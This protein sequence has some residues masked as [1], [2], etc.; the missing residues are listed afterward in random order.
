VRK[1]ASLSGAMPSHDKAKTLASL[2]GYL[3]A[4]RESSGLLP[5]VGDFWPDSECIPRRVIR[6]FF[7]PAP[8]FTAVLCKFAGSPPPGAY[9]VGP[10]G[11]V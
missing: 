8:W 5:L 10:F 9:D 1:V 3:D 2:A 4:Q 11:T 7:R 6:I